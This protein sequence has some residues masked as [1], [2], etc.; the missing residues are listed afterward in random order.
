MRVGLFKK[1][2]YNISDMEKDFTKVA[3]DIIVLA[4]QSNAEGNGVSLENEP[5]V[6]SDA[7]EIIDKNK[8]GMKLKEDGSYG[9][10]NFVYPVETIIRELQERKNDDGTRYCSDLSMSFVEEYK[11]SRFYS[12]DRKLLVI[13]TAYGGSG[14]AFDQQGI[15][16]PLY[17]RTLDMI[18]VGL[19]LNKNNRIVAL[20][21]HQGEHDAYENAQFSYDERYD[22]YYQNL[23]KMF[24]AFREEYKLF[25]FPI[26]TGELCRDWKKR[27]R[28]ES[29][30]VEKA[31]ID[32]CNKI[33]N[34]A[35]VR[36][37]DLP[38]NAEAINNGDLDHFSKESIL[39]LGKRYFEAFASLKEE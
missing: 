10:L 13:K 5:E 25:D 24:L 27:Y 1:D 33:G 28:V 30:A 35:F 16:N 20:L 3:F 39:T 37:F 18:N 31:T 12:P 22:Y 29:E 21:W 6:M 34:A 38:S 8:Y 7:Y 4:G 11:K 26:I 15:G 17:K 23:L 14:F 32:V 36:A 19:S 2:K 9:G